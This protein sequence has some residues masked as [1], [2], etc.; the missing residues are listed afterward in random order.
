MDITKRKQTHTHR[1]Q[2]SRE[3]DQGRDKIGVW[4]LEVQTIMY[5]INKLQG[6]MVQ[7]REDGQYFRIIITG[8]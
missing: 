2:T 5:K 7:H 4:N 6:Y 3:R 8:V 1:E